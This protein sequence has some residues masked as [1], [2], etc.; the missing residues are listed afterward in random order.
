MVDFLTGWMT[1]NSE[2][3]NE[4]VRQ[5]FACTEQRSGSGSGAAAGRRLVSGAHP[6]TAKVSQDV[7]L[8]GAEIRVYTAVSS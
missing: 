2:G 6:L 1:Y 7:D 3:S 5:L 8:V 4:L